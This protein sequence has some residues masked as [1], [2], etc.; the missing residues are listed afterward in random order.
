MYIDTSQA[1]HVGLSGISGRTATPSGCHLAILTYQCTLI[2]GRAI[3]PLSDLPT[4]NRPKTASVRVAGGG[5]VG[6]SIS[7]VG[8]FT[9]TPNLLY[10]P[11]LMDL[12]DRGVCNACV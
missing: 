6:S 11:I 3:A 1:S 10:S 7:V 2:T 12:M 9:P 8:G 5:G 4:G